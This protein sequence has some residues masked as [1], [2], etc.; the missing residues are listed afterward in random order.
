MK[1]QLPNMLY[2]NP[3][4]YNQIFNSKETTF[5]KANPQISLNYTIL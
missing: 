2:L 3:I 5:L 4:K 1:D